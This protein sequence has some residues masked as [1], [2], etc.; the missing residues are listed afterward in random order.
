MDQIE[1][2]H[3]ADGAYHARCR[4]VMRDHVSS[5]EY[6]QLSRAFE[7][8]LADFRDKFAESARASSTERLTDSLP[9][10]SVSVTA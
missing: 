3:S 10:L 5:F 2:G 8:A 9:Q 4:D 6:L 1:P 7:S